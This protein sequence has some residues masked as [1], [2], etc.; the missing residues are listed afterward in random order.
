[1]TTFIYTLV[2]FVALASLFAY[3]YARHYISDAGW[4]KD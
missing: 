4:F 3:L 2:A 1:M